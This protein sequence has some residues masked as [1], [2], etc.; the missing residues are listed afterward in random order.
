MRLSATRARRPSSPVARPLRE[1]PESTSIHGG[2]RRSVRRGKAA[3]R[4]AEQVSRQRGRRVALLDRDGGVEA[5]DEIVIPARRSSPTRRSRSGRTSCARARSAATRQTIDDMRRPWGARTKARDLC[6]RTIRPPDRPRRPLP[7][8]PRLGSDGPLSCSR[9]VSR[10][11]RRT[12]Y[13][14]GVSTRALT[15]PVGSDL[16]KSRASPDCEWVRDRDGGK[17]DRLNR[18]RATYK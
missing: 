7:K 16:P 11:L 5:G 18:V 9:G 13:P 2:S 4:D 1:A 8:L 17:L 12:E 15:R 14:A 6:S 3:S 10:F